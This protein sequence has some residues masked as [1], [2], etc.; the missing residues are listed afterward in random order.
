MPHARAG[1]GK[2]QRLNA[3]FPKMQFAEDR[4]SGEII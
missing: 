2:L 3:R 4:G 1:I